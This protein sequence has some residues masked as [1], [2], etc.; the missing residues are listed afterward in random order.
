MRD[1]FVFY[2]SWQ[3][4]LNRLPD[5]ESFKKV[6]NAMCDSIFDD[7][8]FS[9]KDFTNEELIIIDLTIPLLQAAKANYENGLKGGRPTKINY[10]KAVELK[11]QGFNNSQIAEVFGV[12]KRAIEIFFQERKNEK[13]PEK[14]PKKSNDN[15]NEN[16]NLNDTYNDKETVYL[17]DKDK[18]TVNLNYKD[19]SLNDNIHKK[20]SRFYKP[21]LEQVESF[22]QNKNLGV[23]PQEFFEY[24]EQTNWENV[25]NWQSLLVAW[26]NR[27]IEV[28]NRAVKQ[29]S[30]SDPYAG[31]R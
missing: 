21:T 18:E 13:T 2:K 26:N 3:K 24:Y 15:V 16:L 31:L 28:Y 22:C 17:N 19:N 9:E 30:S 5:G 27:Q 4:S 29:T 14:T 12:S 25:Y 10:E 11:E 7:R 20:N 23:N 1:S 8:E 6:F